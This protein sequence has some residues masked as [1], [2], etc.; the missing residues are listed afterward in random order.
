MAEAG[1]A[2]RARLR[3]LATGA[4]ANLGVSLRKQLL[5]VTHCSRVAVR[6][7][8]TVLVNITWI[9]L[10]VALADVIVRTVCLLLEVVALTARHAL[11][12]AEAWA[13]NILLRSGGVGRS[14]GLIGRALALSIQ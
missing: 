5:F 4:V 13:A 10:V 11:G 14:T 8:R 3:D 2:V 12:P 9:Y 7:L 6:Q 1:S